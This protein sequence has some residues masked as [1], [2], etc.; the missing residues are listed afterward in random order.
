MKSH[1]SQA[2]SAL[3]RKKKFSQRQA[4]ADLGISQAL[5]SHYENGARE[6]KLEFVVRACNYYDVTADY[7]LGRVSESA[8]VTIPVPHDCEGTLRLVAATRAVYD[9]LEEVSDAAL[10]AAVIEYLT[11]PVE[12]A[13]KLI[14]EPD[15]P[16]DP[17]RDANLKL[18]EASLISK[19]GTRRKES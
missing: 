9:A 17:L 1:F 15:A 11:I 19:A 4:A 13:I 3:R 10:N 2:L 18:A 12:N 5:L 14:S 6:P 8:G 7:L 16:Y